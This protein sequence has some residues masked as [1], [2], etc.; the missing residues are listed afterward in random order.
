MR[1]KRRTRTRAAGVGTG[2]ARQRGR[3]AGLRQQRGRGI[4][5]ELLGAVAGTTAKQLLP[6][7]AKAGLKQAAKLSANYAMHR[8]L[9]GV[10]YKRRRPKAQR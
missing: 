10:R 6:K 7:I 9:Q 8:L 2:R 1:R 3:G 5:G 4:A